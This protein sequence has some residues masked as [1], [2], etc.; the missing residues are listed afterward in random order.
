MDMSKGRRDP[1]DMG[2]ATRQRIEDLAEGWDVPAG[3]TDEPSTPA[4]P[5][6]REPPE[7]DPVK[8]KPPK[9]PPARAKRAS[10]PPPPPPARAKRTS[11]PPPP[12]PPPPPRAKRASAPPPPPPPAARPA[13]PPVEVNDTVPTPRQ[14]I[15]IDSSTDDKQDITI[16]S[17]AGGDRDDK[18]VLQSSDAVSFINANEQKVGHL[19]KRPTLR[20]KRGP[21]GDVRYVFTALFGVAGARR[22]LAEVNT[23]LDLERDGRDDRLL[24]AIR[25]MIADPDVDL[26]LIDKA[27]ESL[28][29]IEEERSR[30]AGAAANAEAELES[31]VRARATEREEQLGTIKQREDEGKQIS[32]KLAPLERQAAA[33]RKKA[34]TLQASLRKLDDAMAAKKSSLVTVKGPKAD[35]AAVEADIA[36]LRAERADIANEEPVLAA[37]LDELEPKIASLKVAGKDARAEI[38]RINEAE[39]EAKLRTEEKLAA[40]RARKAVEDRAV[41]EANRTRDDALRLLGEQLCIDRPEVAVKR[42]GAIDQHDIEIAT[43]ER[44]A[45]EL[46]ELVGGVDRAKLARGIGLML[47]ALGAFVALAWL[48]VA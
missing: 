27:R 24:D 14:D 31:L 23:K 39:T 6:P 17:S 36:S 15:T 9:P 41:S 1:R 22:E 25:T 3:T 12:P 35:P 13:T 29:V 2:D 32:E 40:V 47:L 43:L 16:D 46:Q 8:A 26:P 37:Q 19:R 11:A 33:V 21:V 7:D 30:K 44:Q 48:I 34:D 20:R 4:T 10:A 28:T 18:T 38:E 42:L 5:P 45:V